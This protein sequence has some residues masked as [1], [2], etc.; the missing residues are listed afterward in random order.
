MAY[1]NVTLLIKK[2]QKEYCFEKFKSWAGI[3]KYATDEV[4][5]RS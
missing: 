5:V 1:E 2:N 3:F 4:G